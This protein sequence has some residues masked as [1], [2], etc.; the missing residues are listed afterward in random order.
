MKTWCHVLFASATL[1]AA[2]GMHAA[3]GLPRFDHYDPVV[4]N[5]HALDRISKGEVG[6]AA[7]LLERAVLLAPHD[8][9]IRRN[10]ETL[11]ATQAGVRLGAPGISVAPPPLAPASPMPPGPA[12][13]PVPPVP[14]WTNEQ[15]R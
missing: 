13:R 15:A 2:Q 1:L 3:E 7:I 6:T 5:E 12:T 14:Y 10:L 8:T 4:L 11:R 9:R